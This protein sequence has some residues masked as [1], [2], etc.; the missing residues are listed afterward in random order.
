MDVASLAGRGPLRV[1]AAPLKLSELARRT[2]LERGAVGCAFRRLRELGSD[3]GALG[4]EI[5][6]R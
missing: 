4:D 2:G 1:A 6:V 5:R 3:A